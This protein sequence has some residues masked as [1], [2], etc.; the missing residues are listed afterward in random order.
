MSEEPK[1]LDRSEFCDSEVRSIKR[2]AECLQEPFSLAVL[3]RTITVLLQAHFS[4]SKNF[5]N[6]GLKC[7][8]FSHTPGEGS[9]DIGTAWS[10]HYNNDSMPG[11]IVRFDG[12]S[13]SGVGMNDTIST[14]YDTATEFRGRKGVCG[15]SI[16]CAHTSPD[17]AL[18][19]AEMVADVLIGFS[20][21]LCNNMNLQKFDVAKI[22]G[23]K[24]EEQGMYSV[25]VQ[26]SIAYIAS[27]N[28]NVESHRIKKFRMDITA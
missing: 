22:G 13:L 2:L 27:I 20:H 6:D 28:F 14:S 3:L 11:I 8:T 21:E 7:L 9:I 4:N 17:V 12:A 16:T 19:M 15:V 10:Q 18:S 24:K 1:F 25:V 23:I 26:L 5:W